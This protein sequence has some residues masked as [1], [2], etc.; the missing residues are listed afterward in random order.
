MKFLIINA[1]DVGFS[2]AINAAVRECYISGAITGASIMACCPRFNEAVKILLEIGKEEVGVHLTL[3][4]MKKF[5]HNYKSF[6]LKYSMGRI[7]LGK[8][9]EEL[10]GQV[11]KVRDKGLNI[12]HIDSH[13]HIHM[14]PGVLN[15]A[16]KLALEFNIPYVRLPFESSRMMTKSFSVKDA[17]RHVSL[18]AFIPS[19]KRQISQIGL[20]HNDYFLGH[21]HAGRIDDDIL[22]FMISNLREGVTELAVHPSAGSEAFY[23]EFPWYKSTKKE[24]DFLVN[25]TWKEEL[26]GSGVRLVTHKKQ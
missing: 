6:A 26:A 7:D 5:A 9:Y 8:A 11:K 25:K 21:F 13:E 16:I 20:E 12:T 18:A 10:S 24:F 1:D 14:F 3:T 17:V 23:R 19:G 22:R 15:I 4:G 2:D